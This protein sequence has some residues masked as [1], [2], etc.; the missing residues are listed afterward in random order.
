MVNFNGDLLPASSHFTNHH[1]RG[2]RYGDALF[3]RIKSTGK[4]LLFLESH[5]FRLMA[6]MRQLRMEI[7]M[8]FTLEFLQEEI[9]KTLTA[10]GLSGKPAGVRL[11]VFR[12]DGVGYLPESLEVSYLI[13]ATPLA[14]ATFALGATPFTADLFRD[15]YLQADG[16]SRLDHAGKLPQVLASIYARDNGLDTCLLVN[17]RK[18][19]AGGIHGN[20]FLRKGNQIKTPPQGSGCAEGVL[21]K[22]LLKQ[23]WAENPYEITEAVVSPFELQQADELFLLDS[24]TGIQPIT[25]YRKAVYGTEA[26]EYFTRGLNELVLTE[27]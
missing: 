4:S 19:V 17:H 13:E 21:W 25:H 10:A 26:S 5:Y 8:E 3:E 27:A 12:Q 20:L 22:V 1:N 24:L 15:Y 23:K 11:T 7:P 6:S 16:L 2:L 9:D 14:Q 18:E